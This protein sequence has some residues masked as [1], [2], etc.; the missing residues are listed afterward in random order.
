M[1]NSI[2][3]ANNQMITQVEGNLVSDMDGEKVMFS[4]T[5]GKYYNLGEIGGV[6]WELLENPHTTDDIVMDLLTKYE[7]DKKTCEDQVFAFIS[8]LHQEGLINIGE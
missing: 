6:I 8:L 7:V 1:D 4:I 3:L 5:N 2:L